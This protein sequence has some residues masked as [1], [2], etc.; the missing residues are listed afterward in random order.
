MQPCPTRAMLVDMA[1]SKSGDSVIERIVRVL[2]TFSSERTVQ[3][4]AEIG[5]RANLPQ[6]TAHRIVESI[7]EVGF[8]TKD[9]DNRVQLGMRLW[10]LALRGSFALRLR[11]A[12][13]P[14]MYGVQ[15]KIRQHTQLAVLE[16][17]EALFLE[18]ISHPNAGANIT[19]VAGRLPLHASSSG[20]ILLAHAEPRL[21]ERIL[22]S[23]LES[24]GPQTV[25]DPQ[26]LQRFLRDIKAQGYVIAR[27]SIEAVSTGIAVPIRSA[28]VV[29][30]ALSVVQPIEKDTSA[31]LEALL[32][33]AAKIEHALSLP[34]NENF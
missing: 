19:R 34:F 31:T 6:S 3:T 30:A 18:R 16:N 23:K 10:E 33:A 17:E 2:E 24:V 26:S 11:Q 22:N 14:H 8:L 9:A 27:A 21:R 25:T 28:G 4:V 1:N 20:L 15:E 5:R 12:A 29:R 13:L 32:N 7:V